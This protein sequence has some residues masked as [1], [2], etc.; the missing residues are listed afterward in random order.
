MDSQYS[1]DIILAGTKNNKKGEKKMNKVIGIIIIIASIAL[2]L[3]LGIGVMLMGGIQQIIAS[4]NPIVESGLT[5]G[6]VKVILASTVG[7]TTAILGTAIGS[8]I[9]GGNED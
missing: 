4:I 7:W 6:I 1:Q 2:G 3:W 9:M 5:A 8:T